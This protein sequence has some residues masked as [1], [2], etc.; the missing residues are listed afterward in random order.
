MK[1]LILSMDNVTTQTSN[2]ENHF[3]LV[4][5]RIH[6]FHTVQCWWARRAVVYRPVEGN[7]IA[8]INIFF[9]N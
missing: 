6:D 9:L 8:G 3:L 4:L 5:K 2:A 1:T 7:N